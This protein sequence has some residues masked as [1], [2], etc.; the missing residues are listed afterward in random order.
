MPL[1]GLRLPLRTWLRSA[2]VA[3]AFAMATLSGS[4]LRAQ[5]ML[6]TQQTESLPIQVTADYS[7]E[8]REE[9]GSAAML[10][11][12]CQI[13]QGEL[14]LSAQKMVVWH[15]LESDD[16]GRVH[17]LVVYL[18]D[19][20]RIDDPDQSRN[21]PARIVELSTRAGIS[22]QIPTGRR[23]REEH[24]DSD[25]LF[26]RAVARLEQVPEG[27]IEQAQFAF[28]ARV[29]QR[30]GGRPGPFSALTAA[31]PTAVAQNPVGAPGV[32]PGVR[33]V[34][35]FPRSAV[36]YNI[37]SYRNSKTTPPEQVWV[38]TG[39]I[40]LIVEGVGQAGTVDL[41]AD[42]MVIWTQGG[43][44][45][46]EFRQESMQS[47]N[48]PFQVYMEGN[49]V[50]R[51]GQNVAKAARAIY[52]AREDR[53][54][55]LNAELKS[56]FPDIGGSVR[57]RAE[58]IRQLSQK[59]FQARNAWTSSSQYGKPGYRLQSSEVFLDY[60]YPDPWL[61]LGKPALDP[62]TGAAA[63]TEIPYVTALDNTFMVDDVP[64]FYSPFISG[65]AEDPNIP[66][67][68][69]FFRQ[70]NVFGTAIRSTWDMYQLLGLNEPPGVEWDLLADYR[71]KRGPAIG[72]GTRY[73]G[74]ELFG[75]RGRY[76]GDG[77]MYYVNDGGRDN[78]GSDRRS[79]GFDGADRG[80]I[81]GHHRQD[82]DNGVIIQG[83]IGYL[84]DRNFLEQY[85]E[86][87]EFDRGKDVETFINV[88]QSIDNVAW[89]VIGRPQLNQFENT[90]RWLP[91]G[92]LYVL[93][94]PL[95]DGN[96]L[97][98]THTS[99]GYGQLR[100]ADRP[101]DPNDI[102]TP[103]PYIV[104]AEGAVLMTRHELTAPFNLG[105]VNI[106]PFVMGEAAYWGEDFT[107]DSI[108]RLFLNA[109]V[110]GSMSFWNVYPTV[111][112]DTFNLNGLAHK[113]RLE[114]EYSWTDSSRDFST[115]PQY[116][117]ID[118]DAQERFRQRFLINSFMGGPLPAQFDPR[119]YAIRNGTGL[120]LTAPYNEL[121]DDQQVVRMAIRQRLQTKVG[122]MGNQRI[123]DWMTLDLEAS[124]FPD[125]NRDNFGEDFGL[126]GARY[127][128]N[129]G[130]RT[131]ILANVLYDLFEPG[132]QLWNLGIL[133]QRSERGSLYVGLRQVK[134]GP[135]DSEI[136]T[137]SYS[138]RMSPKWISTFGTAFD[139]KEGRNVGQSLT[140]TR[141]G[142]DFLVHMGA[143]VD[144]SK[145]NA[146][147]QL[148]LEPRFGNKRVS[149]NNNSPLLN[150]LIP[151]Q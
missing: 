40:N 22:N 66:L 147:I 25:P 64:L 88:R 73:E 78:L 90:T 68:S 15:R 37:L 50:I 11:G 106:V 41:A 130:E 75:L 126:L 140:I 36:P 42:R 76:R 63:P 114:A 3:F 82:L 31:N 35:V 45:F 14:V 70:D 32:D 135:I 132:Q 151:P 84:S 30:K 55:L 112:S 52:D 21:E 128:W 131:A 87:I 62:V 77:L 23:V 143:N 119:F 98:S 8:W 60:R 16:A 115:I 92:D 72:T 129:V 97:Y 125:A 81:T 105:P 111:Q 122:P 101:D 145:G 93:S 100:R 69:I 12:R 29:R 1:S 99:A 43:E 113:I 104:D 137:A 103:I 39:G 127:S 18:E 65:P 71:S 83:E 2:A 27:G 144:T 44:D 91:R 120:D 89:D 58:Q 150:S 34:R 139:L 142:A 33:R 7:Q 20:A 53:G 4:V 118:E 109:G 136:L 17:H 67:R 57:V 24:G 51:Q 10:R 138:Y 133:T 19:E 61:G 149:S 96:L 117:E 148:S 46:E 124:F 26:Q 79:L 48:Q 121:V 74:T 59:S 9:G 95:F 86:A 54:L 134:G 6:G 108:S 49:I 141:V 110:R 123:R 102:F 85:Y 5:G 38:L 13:M 80:R 116:N 94:E 28:P 107:G 47:R 146:G 56:Y